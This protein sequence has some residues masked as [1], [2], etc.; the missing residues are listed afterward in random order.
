MKCASSIS[1]VTARNVSEA[2]NSGGADSAL[3]QEDFTMIQPEP[4][5][6]THIAVIGAGASGLTA[7]H[8]LKQLAFA[9]A[10]RRGNLLAS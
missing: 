3:I 9:V 6:N 7:A 8:T 5:A 1:I 2:E 4:S 10:D